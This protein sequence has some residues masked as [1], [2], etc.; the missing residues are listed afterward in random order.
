MTTAAAKKRKIQKKGGNSIGRKESTAAVV[1]AAVD[2]VHNV[3]NDIDDHVDHH[4]GRIVLSLYD[5]KYKRIMYTHFAMINNSTPSASSI[6][7]TT[8]TT[9]EENEEEEVRIGRLAL[10]ALKKDGDHHQQQQQQ[11]LCIYNG[12]GR[13]SKM[14][15]LEVVD[16]N[17][18]L[19]SEYITKVFV[20]NE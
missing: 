6:T 10:A 8:M 2:E 13:L 12:R 19:T 15:K 18:A 16:D 1:A 7:T 4:Q 17:V 3:N 9:D 20:I 11:Q 5:E 14:S